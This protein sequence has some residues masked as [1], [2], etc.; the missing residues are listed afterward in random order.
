MVDGIVY[1]PTKTHIVYVDSESGLWA[2]A[3]ADAGLNQPTTPAVVNGVAYTGGI[4][5]GGAEIGRAH[6]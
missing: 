6:V 1:V 5:A 3:T 2:K 4:A